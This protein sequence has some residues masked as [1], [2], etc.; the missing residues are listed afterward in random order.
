MPPTPSCDKSLLAMVCLVSEEHLTGEY[1]QLYTYIHWLICVTLTSSPCNI[2]CTSITLLD[3]IETHSL[4]KLDYPCIYTLHSTNISGALHTVQWL[5]N[6]ASHLCSRPSVLN[7]IPTREKGGMMRKG[8]VEGW[9]RMKHLLRFTS[10]PYNLSYFQDFHFLVKADGK[11][12]MSFLSSPRQIYLP[13]YF[14][15]HHYV[16]LAF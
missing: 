13:L 9:G 3:G 15:K 12:V 4:G 8:G 11:M 6:T 5:C 16:V 14:I 1:I 10:S 2:S 7:V